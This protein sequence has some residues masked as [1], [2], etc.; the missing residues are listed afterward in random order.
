MSLLAKA[1]VGLL[2]TIATVA[3]VAVSWVPG[4]APTVRWHG[5]LQRSHRLAA[6]TVRV[7]PGEPPD[8]LDLES[9]LQRADLVVAAKLVEITEVEG[10]P[11]GGTSE[12]R[13]STASTWSASSKASSL[14]T[15]LDDQADL[16]VYQFAKPVIGSSGQTLLILL[17]RQGQ[18]YCRPGSDARPDPSPD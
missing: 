7:Q 3:C 6:A 4:S 15:P 16:G 10:G 5:A 8:V 12:S 14:V 17:A 2:T 1:L 13:I 18:F 11:G 9:S